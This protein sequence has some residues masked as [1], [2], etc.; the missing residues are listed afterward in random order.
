VGTKGGDEYA[1]Q[2]VAKSTES[3]GMTVPASALSSVEGLAPVVVL[4]ARPRPMVDSLPKPGIAGTPHGNGRAFPTAAGDGS[5]SGLSTKRVVVSLSERLRS[6]AEHRGADDSSRA[7]KR[8]KDLGV[9]MPPTFTF[10]WNLTAKLRKDGVDSPST[11]AGL[12]SDELEPGQQKLRM[13]RSSFETPRSKLEGRLTQREAQL[14]GRDASDPML[15]QNS[16]ELIFSEPTRV[17]RRRGLEEQ[18]PQPGLV[19]RGTELE[20][21]REEAMELSPEPIGELPEL[22]LE[23]RI[24]P[25]QLSQSNYER[26]VDL[27][28]AEMAEI[29]AKGIRQNEGIEAVIFRAGHGMAI[30]KSVELLGIDSED[31]K[32]TLEQGF[33]DGAVGQLD[34]D[35][36][37][38]GL[39]VAMLEKRIDE[40]VDSHGRMLDAVLQQFSTFAVEQADL[41]ELTAVVNAN[42]Q[43]VG[44]AHIGFTSVVKSGP[45]LGTASPLYWRS[46]RNSP[47]DVHLGF[48][49]RDA[50]PPQALVAL[51]PRMAFP[52]EWP[53]VTS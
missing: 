45:R 52:A 33:D 24:D 26:F 46:R 53:V 37:S 3:A 6:L 14:L 20:Q 51:G 10:L 7:W 40:M 25:A 21:L 47:R 15:P 49:R 41:V 35:G 30:S 2:S 48:P 1:K 22:F 28:L 5:G 9:A 44:C 18:I 16:G 43:N 23:L 34:G 19:G 17:V 36:T 50:G 13:L 29:R 4:N 32:P 8:E 11:I 39:R 31:M 12:L 42:E 38:I 27:E